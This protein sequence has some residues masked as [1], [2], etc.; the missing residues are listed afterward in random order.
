MCKNPPTQHCRLIL[1]PIAHVSCQHRPHVQSAKVLT[2]V[3]F[4]IW[5]HV[6][7]NG[8]HNRESNDPTSGTG[9][10]RSRSHPQSCG[11]EVAC[12]KGRARDARPEILPAQQLH[13][14]LHRDYH[15][16]APR[17]ARYNAR[18][19]FLRSLWSVK[20]QGQ[21][22][23]SASQPLVQVSWQPTWSE[24]CRFAFKGG[25]LVRVIFDPTFDWVSWPN[26]SGGLSGQASYL[27]P[28]DSGHS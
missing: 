16:T 6:C 19:L 13:V 25:S 1:P 10:D 28:A 7:T 12:T 24:G 21:V 18:N 8:S 26:G 17:P 22:V 11:A 2:R 20:T 9:K 3:S 14:P 5:L 15:P 23:W 4:V 27:K